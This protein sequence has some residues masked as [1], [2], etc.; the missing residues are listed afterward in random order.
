MCVCV[1]VCVCVCICLLVWRQDWTDERLTWNKSAHNNMEDI[2]VIAKS[3]WLPEFA[4]I[5]G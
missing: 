4:V 1:C 3:L 5:N 2:I